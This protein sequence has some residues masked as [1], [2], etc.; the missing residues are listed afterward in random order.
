MHSVRP[1]LLGA[2]TTIFFALTGLVSGTDSANASVVQYDLTQDTC[3]GGCGLSNYGTVVVSD[4]SGGGVHVVA[5]LVSTVNFANTGALADALVFSLSGAPNI[6]IANLTTGDFSVDDTTGGSPNISAGGAFGSFE[7][8]IACSTCGS[9][10]SNPKHGPITFDITD[11]SVTTAMFTDG[12][13]KKGSSWVETGTYF[14][15]DVIGPNGNTGR[16][17]TPAGHAP[18]SNP[19]P[20]VPEPAT[21]TLLGAA[22]AGFG[23]M[24]RRRR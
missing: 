1:Q 4:I 20:S 6:T 11:T 22:L 21:L 12:I 7:Y 3:S 24:R 17:G 14:V 15:V 23:A 18:S 19:P 9:G 10:G 8:G 5:S 2:V 13:K 16:I